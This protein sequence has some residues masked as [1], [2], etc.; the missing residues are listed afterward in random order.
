VTPTTSSTSLMINLLS[1]ALVL[2]MF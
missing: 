2:L 1:F